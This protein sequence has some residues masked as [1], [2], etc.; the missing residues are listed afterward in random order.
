[1]NMKEQDLH[2]LLFSYL[3]GELTKEEARQVEE[4]CAADPAF[5]RELELTRATVRLLT[6]R[7]PEGFKPFFWTRLSARLDAEEAARQAW[8]WVAKRLIPSMVT[9]TLLAGIFLGY[10]A[11]TDYAADGVEDTL[12]FYEDTD[13][14]GGASGQDLT[15]ESILETLMLQNTK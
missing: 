2:T 9:A 15:T 13:Q 11:R 12:A 4:R 14:N 3:L 1:M 7:K 6:H 5:A 8:I 10:T